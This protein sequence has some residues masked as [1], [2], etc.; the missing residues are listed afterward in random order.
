VLH[1]VL[2]SCGGTRNRWHLLVE[3]NHGASIKTRTRPTV[4][5]VGWLAGWPAG[6]PALVMLPRGV[7]T[8]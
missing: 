1:T 6:R 5:S 2:L 4:H 8:R 3:R 7:L